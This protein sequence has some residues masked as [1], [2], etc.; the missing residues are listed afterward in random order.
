MNS[1]IESIIGLLMLVL[2]GSAIGQVYYAIK[3]E[4]IHRVRREL[5]SHLESYTRKLT[6]TRLKY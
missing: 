3:K 5:P 4:T 1:V 2:T 6:G